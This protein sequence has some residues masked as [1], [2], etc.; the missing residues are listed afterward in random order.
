M[1]N[2]PASRANFSTAATSDRQVDA[3][4]NSALRKLRLWPAIVIV[5]FFWAFYFSIDHIEMSMFVRFISRWSVEGLVLLSFVAW[6]LAF[7]RARWFDRLL[8]VVVMI[9]GP[10]WPDC[11]RIKSR[12][13]RWG[14]W[15][16]LWRDCRSC[17]LDGWFGWPSVIDCYGFRP[18]CSG[19]DYA[20]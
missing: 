11:W 18:P 12:S 16:C 15:A 4:P 20:C 5:G 8:P 7:S 9:G 1:S 3:T 19:S 17:S 13:V 2:A 14:S 10:W 6:W